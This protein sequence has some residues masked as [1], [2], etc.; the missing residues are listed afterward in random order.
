MSGKKSMDYLGIVREVARRLML[1]DDKGE[2]IVLDSITLVE[3]VAT[4]EQETKLNIP[5]AE[6]NDKTFAS[7]ETIATFL[8]SLQNIAA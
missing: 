6:I 2:L 5:M 3:F 8:Q 1:I 4:L 7:L